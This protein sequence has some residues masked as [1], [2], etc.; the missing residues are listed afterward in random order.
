MFLDELLVQNKRG[1]L[2]SYNQEEIIIAI[3]KAAARVRGLDPV[4]GDEGKVTDTEM[5]K[6][7]SDVETSLLTLSTNVVQTSHLHTL[8]EKA[9]KKHAPDVYE[10]YYQYHS[11]QLKAREQYEEVMRKCDSLLAYGDVQ[12]ANADSTLSSVI[13]C[14][15]ADYLSTARYEDRFLTVL[16]KQAAAIGYI[17]PHDRNGRLLY[18]FNCCLFNIAAVLNN[19][20]E[21]NNVWYTK[22]KTL[23]VAFDVCGDITIMA[24]SQQYG[25]FTLPEIDKVLAPYAELS[26][27]K[28]YER[29]VSCGISAEKSDELATQDVKRDFKQGFQGW[30]IKFNTVASSR[31][32]YPFIT[33]TLGLGQNKWEQMASITALEVRAEGQGLPGKKKPVL[34]PKIVFLFDCNLHGDGKPLEK[35]FYAGLQCSSKAMYPDWLSLTG[36]GYVPSIYKKYGTPISPMG[37]RAFLSPWYERGGMQPADENDRPVFVGRFNLGAVSLH[38]PMILA[39][40]RH[41]NRDFYDVL[42]YYLG[43]IRNIHKRTY[44]YIGQMPAS[45]NPL[46]FCYGGLL[47]G[48]LKPTD[49]IK[50]LLKSATFSFGVTALN[51][52]QRLYNGKSL[53][54]DGNFALEVME[55]INRKITEFKHEDGLLYAVYGTPAESLC[56]LQVTQFRSQYGMIEGVSDREYVSNSFHCHV[57][58]QISP[59]EKQDSENRF[60]DLFNGGKIQ[61]CRYSLGYNTEAIKALVLR[62]MDMGLYEGVNLALS[63]CD[64]CGYSAIEIGETCPSCGSRAITEINRMNGYLGYS[65][66]GKYASADDQ[67]GK[68]KIK[69]RY[70][71]AKQ[72]EISE[73][74]S[75]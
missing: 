46:A 2:S 17:Y 37:C 11:A 51:E 55:Y 29:Y 13:K 22:P 56:G 8:V 39:K 60:W 15:F 7:L 12:N 49:K 24:A 28:Y 38:L 52:L 70:N 1:I 69:T 30:E 44:E 4:T 41:E 18:P 25:G 10:A 20:C 43:M 35:V 58:E 53:Y 31:G 57:T 75:M 62:A 66:V 40:A 3:N 48:T 19:G 73:R 64:S 5:Y 63:Y 34:F 61:Y 16:E 32:D 9:L 36:D 59:I 54:E 6:I 65:R 67:N 26:Y 45:R 71:H 42:D 72:V 27:Q 33:I 50:P 21:V 74:V 23:D 47:G 14:F 68:L